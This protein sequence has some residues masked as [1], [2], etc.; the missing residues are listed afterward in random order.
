MSVPGGGIITRVKNAEEEIS[1]LK[2]EIVKLNLEIDNL[3]LELSKLV[4]CSTTK[5][6]VVAP[7]PMR[8]GLLGYYY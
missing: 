2:E 6:N 7:I 4:I 1:I 8:K 5:E 3:K